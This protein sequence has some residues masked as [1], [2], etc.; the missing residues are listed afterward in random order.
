M[1]WSWDERKRAER[2]A[3]DLLARSQGCARGARR[4]AFDLDPE[5]PALAPPPFPDPTDAAV[6]RL[7]Q[8][9][10]DKGLAAAAALGQI[11]TQ[12]EARGT[13]ANDVLRR[14]HR[15][16]AVNQVSVA[17]CV[18]SLRVLSAIDWNEFFEQQSQVERI[19]RDDPAG[20][21]A[22]QDFATRDRY[23]RDRRGDRPRRRRRR[24][25]RGP[26]RRSSWRGPDAATGRRGHVGYYL[27][28]RGLAALKA[29]FRP[30]SSG[31]PAP[32]R[33]RWRIP[34]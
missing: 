11:E 21:Y 15:R 1:L 32:S 23:R 24:A 14:D 10:R 27:V 12:L 25:G 34:G 3:A 22:Q 17:N 8:L 16:Q 6:V 4:R 30:S 28:D 7:L 29:E 26:P 18:I 5:R 13:D 9:L 31:R 33:R 2:W 20:V 19:L